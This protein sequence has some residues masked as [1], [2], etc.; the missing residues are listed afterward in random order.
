MIRKLLYIIVL[1]LLII[2]YPLA[3]EGMS[4]EVIFSLLILA[5]ILIL[6]FIQKVD[7]FKDLKGYFFKHSTLFIFGFIIVHF[8]YLIDYLLGNTLME[9]KN[10]W[11]NTSVVVKSLVLSIIALI[12]FFLGYLV[13]RKNKFEKLNVKSQVLRV[14]GLEVLALVFL[15]AY[16]YFINPLYFLG[17]YGIIDM[18]SESAYIIVL[19][20]VVVVAIIIQNTRNLFIFGKTNISFKNF[21]LEQ[22]WIINILIVIYLLSVILS[23]DRGPIM[24][25]GLVLVGNYLF[26]TKRKIRLL[27]FIIFVF[28]GSFLI[29]S[30]GE[31]RALNSYFSFTEKLNIVIENKNEN[32]FTTKSFFSTTQELATSVRCLHYSVYYV[33]KRHEFLLGRFQFQQVTST[34]PFFSKF[35]NIIFSDNHFKYNGSPDFITWL[36]QGEFTY[37]GTGTSIVAD[38]YLDFGLFGV[39]IGMFFFGFIISIAEQQ[40]YSKLLPTLFM[41]GFFISYLASIIYISRSSVLIVLKSVVWVFLFL[42]L[43]EFI[44]NKKRN[45]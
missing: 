44:F 5:G 8:Q 14:K 41:H 42:I 9:D 36:N 17:N 39:V 7:K 32:R 22:G 24:F 31:V 27:R 11:V 6:D 45:I 21:L 43:N 38:F 1:V 19:F 20:E 33:P 28:F 29:S 40:M 13:K 16:F 30:L 34:V 10:I 12:S 18:G 23:G 15:T 26:L 37:S 4:K 2:Y 3:S 25:F 35:N